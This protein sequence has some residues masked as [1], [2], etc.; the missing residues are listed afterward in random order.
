M[1]IKFLG[2]GASDWSLKNP[3]NS[4][5]FRYFS[6]AIIDDKLLIDCGPQIIEA[7]EKY[8]T[9]PASV[10]YII[11]THKHSDHYSEESIKSLADFGAEYT[12][13]SAG[14]TIKIDKYT[15]CCYKGNHGTANETVHFIISDSKHSCFYGLDGAWLL[16]D[17]IIGIKQ[18]K[19]DLAVIDGTIGFV[20]GDY[21]IFEHN[22]LN[23]VIEIKKSLSDY[24]KQFCIS[25]M[26]YTLHTGQKELE[27]SLKKENIIVAYDGLEINL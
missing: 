26:A 6:A 1:K 22:N 11:N 23:M 9:E 7:M 27:D 25:H 14:E 17:E 18:H 24:V 12:E 8:G 10:K 19:P 2:T 3:E 5:E 21:R 13:L 15:I 4:K 20:D 16:Y